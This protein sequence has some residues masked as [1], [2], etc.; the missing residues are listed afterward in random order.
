MAKEISILQ[1][2]CTSRITA[3]EATTPQTKHADRMILPSSS[4][5]HSQT[6]LRVRGSRWTCRGEKSDLVIFFLSHN[7][8][9]PQDSV[10]TKAL[11]E[12]IYAQ[13]K[14]D[15]TVV[16]SLSPF[17]HEL[18]R[19][20]VLASYDPMA[21]PFWGNE[22]TCLPIAHAQSKMQA[23]FCVLLL[24]M[25]AFGTLTESLWIRHLVAPTITKS[26]LFFSENFLPLV[27]SGW[28]LSTTSSLGFVRQS[29]CQAKKIEI[30]P[31]RPS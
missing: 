8:I 2:R 25:A 5:K 17:V 12:F 20:A 11:L 18:A 13:N 10:P 28:H 16:E 29:V 22:V 7:K 6:Y 1:Y 19:T 15:F 26:F 21:L 30:S 31:H 3:K 23:H 9:L 27:N 24:V 4:Q 14:T